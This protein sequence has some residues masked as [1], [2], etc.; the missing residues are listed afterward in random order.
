MY[1]GGLRAAA[2]NLNRLSKPG[3]AR[4]QRSPSPTLGETVLR[5]REKKGRMMDTVMMSMGFQTK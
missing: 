5:E 2:R 4:K 3:V 1:L